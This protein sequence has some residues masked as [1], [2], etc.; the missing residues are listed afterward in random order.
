[1][2]NHWHFETLCN[3]ASF[4]DLKWFYYFVLWSTDSKQK[5]RSA[6]TFWYRLSSYLQKMFLNDFSTHA[7]MCSPRVF[8]RLDLIKNFSWLWELINL[9]WAAPAQTQ[10]NPRACFAFFK[11]RGLHFSLCLRGVIRGRVCGKKKLN[12]E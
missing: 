7:H 2:W 9:I 12:C 10:M 5:I 8:G 4:T 1:M 6:H 3:K 11:L